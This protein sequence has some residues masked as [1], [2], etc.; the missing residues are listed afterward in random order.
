MHAVGGYQKPLQRKGSE[1]HSD[2]S[3]VTRVLD[4]INHKKSVAQ[5]FFFGVL[6]CGIQ[7]SPKFSYCE[8]QS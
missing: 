1:H 6:F 3:P 5:V 8:A 7:I 2:A 4:L